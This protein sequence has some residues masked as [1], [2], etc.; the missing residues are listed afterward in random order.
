VGR[1]EE[2]AEWLENFSCFAPGILGATSYLF[3]L[4]GEQVH[5]VE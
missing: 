1:E 2:E 5:H 4:H 3:E